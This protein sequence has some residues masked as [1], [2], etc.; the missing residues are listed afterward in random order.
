MNG[1]LVKTKQGGG[2]GPPLSDSSV[3]NFLEI[4]ESEDLCSSDTIIGKNNPN[5]VLLHFSK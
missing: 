3:T 5:T 1:S 4:F 2:R